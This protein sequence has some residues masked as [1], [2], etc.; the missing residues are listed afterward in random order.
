MKIDCGFW[1]SKDE[2]IEDIQEIDEMELTNN[3]NGL[4]YK[5]IDGIKI[6]DVFEY[7]DRLGKICHYVVSFLHTRMKHPIATV[8]FPDGYS[9]NI[10][11]N[12]VKKDKFIKNIDW[13]TIHDNY[14]EEACRYL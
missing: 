11:L 8:L 3:P 5:E 2:Y 13:W 14:I 6:G 9:E 1:N 7:K 10:S 4:T 12:T